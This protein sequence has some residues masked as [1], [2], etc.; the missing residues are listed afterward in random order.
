M[1]VW[2]DPRE[3]RALAIVLVTAAVLAACGEDKASEQKARTVTGEGFSVQ[4]PGKAERSVST[5]QSAAGPVR[6][7]AYVSESGSEG[8]SVSVAPLPAGAKGDL[9]GA[10]N[11]AA[12][13]TG[14]T[15]KES[16]STR[17]GGFP[18]RDAR[19][20]DA[21]DRKG[22]KGTLFVRVILAKHKLFQLQFVQQGGDVKSPPQAYT[23]F[24]GSLKIS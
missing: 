19:I 17:Y 20:T 13:N 1:R 8:F 24:V 23:T 15:A 11:G 4:M 12:A 6:V 9:E 22:R 21:K 10:V 7:T 16:V 18:A 3:L 5:V 2:V 14:G